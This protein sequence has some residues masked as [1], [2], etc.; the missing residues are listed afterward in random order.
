[1]AIEGTQ[2]LIEESLV[3]CRLFEIPI[4]LGLL[5][6]LVLLHLELITSFFG[7]TRPCLRSGKLRAF[8]HEAV[9]F[10]YEEVALSTHWIALRSG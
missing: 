8:E 3:I 7:N 1:M 4:F 2:W 9:R 5:R 10:A 6:I